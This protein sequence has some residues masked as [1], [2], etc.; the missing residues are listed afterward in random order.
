MIS[1]PNA[2]VIA[3]IAG[4][5]FDASLAIEYDI[6][7]DNADDLSNTDWDAMANIT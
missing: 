4:I 1:L 5:V 7:C 6:N 3:V 2:L